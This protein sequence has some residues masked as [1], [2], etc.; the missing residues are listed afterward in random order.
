MKRGSKIALIVVGILAALVLVVGVL[1]AVAVMSLN[2]EPDVPN[3]SVLVVKVEGV[4]PDYANADELSARF[5]GAQTN[6]LSNLLLQLRKAKADNRIKA[7][8]LDIGMVEAGWAKADEIRD[9]VADFRK[10]GK[11]IYAYME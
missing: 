1:I 10:S 3:N 8:L 4:L 2:S 7:V 5:F 11:P 6:S 9:A